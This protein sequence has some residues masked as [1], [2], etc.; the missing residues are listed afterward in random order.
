MSFEILKFL[1]L[2]PGKTPFA[3]EKATKIDRP[4]VYAAIDL[5]N[6]AGLIEKK[7]EKRHA[8]GMSRTYGA[9]IRGFVALLQADSREVILNPNESRPRHFNVTKKDVQAF[10]EKKELQ[11]FLPLI[12]GKWKQFRDSGVEDLA[13]EQLLVAAN[14][15][16]SERNDEVRKLSEISKGADPS[17]F[18]ALEGAP[19]VLR[20]EIYEQMFRR[21]FFDLDKTRDRFGEAIR[22]DTEIVQRIERQLQCDQKAALQEVTYLDMCLKTIRGETTTRHLGS[23]E[24]SKENSEWLDRFVKARARYERAVGLDK[25]VDP[26]TLPTE[27]EVNDDLMNASLESLR[28][29]LVLGLR[30]DLDTDGRIAKA[31]LEQARLNDK[32][33][34]DL[35]RMLQKTI[36]D[37]QRMPEIYG[38]YLR[39]LGARDLETVI[40]KAESLVEELK[41]IDPSD[42]AI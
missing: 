18:D 23:L 30:R 37:Y 5:L 15:V 33:R 22:A 17:P 36:D 39:G 32:Y 42:K 6:K 4:T 12:F 40:S 27:Q 20:D 38:E 29:F 13:Y 21:R 28:V 11:E 26:S 34:Q 35:I 19:A 14:E 8:L 25:G 2:N 24:L 41:R 16:A 3:T 7:G 10:A 9:N 31:D 1:V